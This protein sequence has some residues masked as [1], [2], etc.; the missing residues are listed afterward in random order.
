MPHAVFIACGD[1]LQAN[2]KLNRLGATLEDALPGALRDRF[3][4]GCSQ[5]LAQGEPVPLE[6]SYRDEDD[7][8]ILFRCVMMPVRAVSDDVSFI[9]G[10][11]SHKLAA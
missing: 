1:S 10:A 8:E 11:Y 7:E 2:W 6:G 9:Y 4:A 3:T 5:T